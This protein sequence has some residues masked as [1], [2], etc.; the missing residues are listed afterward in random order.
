MAQVTRPNDDGRCVV[1]VEA[2]YAGGDARACRLVHAAQLTVMETVFP[3]SLGIFAS[4]CGGRRGVPEDSE[5]D[6]KAGSSE[7]ESKEEA[8]TNHQ[9]DLPTETG[10]PATAKNETPAEAAGLAKDGYAALDD[11][12]YEQ[13]YK[14]L[15]VGTP[16]P[17]VAHKM[18]KDGKDPGRIEATAPFAFASPIGGGTGSKL[19]IGGLKKP[20][21]RR[22]T[23]KQLP[24]EFHDSVGS[25]S[26][27]ADV[28][29]L[30][31]IEL[32]R[33]EIEALF[34]QSTSSSKRGAALR[35]AGSEG[36]AVST[37]KGGP[38]IEPVAL[39]RKRATNVAI[40]L[41][42]GKLNTL[43]PKHVRAALRR[44]DVSFF[45][46]DQLEALA[47]ATPTNE[48]ASALEKRAKKDVKAQTNSYEAYAEA[49]RF[50]LRVSLRV[51]FYS[52]RVS[53]LRFCAS[54]LERVGS[55]EACARLLRAASGQVHTSLRLK[56]VL[57]YV[58]KLS[59]ELEDAKSLEFQSPSQPSNDK[60][61]SDA[62]RVRRTR[63]DGKI[64]GF[65]LASLL[66]LHELKA[67]DRQTSALEFVVGL[68]VKNNDFHTL[69]FDDD[70]PDAK[71]AQRVSIPAC[72]DELN[73]L[74]VG[75]HHFGSLLEADTRRTPPADLPEQESETSAMMSSKSCPNLGATVQRR[76]PLQLLSDDEDG[77]I[78][79]S[80]SQTAAE[81]FFA[82]ATARVAQAGAGL[83]AAC[84]AYASVLGYL[85]EDPK[86]P[87]HEFFEIFVVFANRFRE[88]RAKHDAKHQSQ[89]TADEEERAKARI[90]SIDAKMRRRTV[91]Q[92]QQPT[93]VFKR[94]RPTGAEASSGEAGIE[95]SDAP[96][97][98]P[99][100]EDD[101]VAAHAEAAPSQEQS[102]PATPSRAA[103][104]EAMLK[105][106]LAPP[107]IE[108]VEQAA[109]EAQVEHPPSRL[110]SPST[111]S[112]GDALDDDDVEAIRDLAL[113]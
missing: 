40:S 110:V 14:M 9:V 22:A 23:V 64:F 91:A 84:A 36:G 90:A 5:D 80:L 113:Y 12:E 73:A 99:A 61:E 101:N 93:R 67:F 109:T 43:P 112:D 6:E 27:W 11:E 83:E 45:D 21:R 85:N 70:I 25:N 48:E 30:N 95:R 98:Q 94:R 32:H 55:L 17:A 34:V 26:I 76:A 19:S 47:A 49:E 111:D 7:S 58:L 106:R 102:V 46:M 71:L 104:L 42:G 38:A 4:T 75:V 56:K 2:G 74:V 24:L 79:A 89:S 20:A 13:Y 72:R 92:E 16:A 18:L 86:M 59:R 96:P 108:D 81:A 10:A 66:R 51:D 53:A 68:M 57:T 3:P 97:P 69:D 87:A 65:R 1:R 8:E 41:A 31:G 29:S 54:F 100:V 37:K 62:Q 44:L 105:S 28:R 103:A 107:M 39:A 63:D 88:A 52:K 15:K 60:M 78:E 82:A 35:S 50:M 33:P 77:G